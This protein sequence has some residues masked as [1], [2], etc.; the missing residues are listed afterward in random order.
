MNQLYKDMIPIGTTLDEGPD[1]GWQVASLPFETDKE[2][3][4]YMDDNKYPRKIYK[5][6]E[7]KGKWYIISRPVSR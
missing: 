7:I 6:K 3:E 5:A 1:I 2:A 4:Y